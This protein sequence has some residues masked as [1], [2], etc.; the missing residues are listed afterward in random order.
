MDDNK[1]TFLKFSQ[2]S[3]GWEGHIALSESACTE[4]RDK[5]S[6]HSEW[7]IHP[8]FGEASRNLLKLLNPPFFPEDETLI[9]DPRI[10]ET[11]SVEFQ[12]I[13]RVTSDE[14][15]LEEGFCFG[16]DNRMIWGNRFTGVVAQL[17]YS[18]VDFI[19]AHNDTLTI[20][21]KKLKII[22][23]EIPPAIHE[24]DNNQ[25]ANIENISPLFLLSELFQLIAKQNSDRIVK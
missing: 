13:R 22:E 16:T 6:I 1:T 9:W 2:T 10:G 20:R 17:H 11:T 14:L 18:E 12:L 23:I 4:W 21:T 3:P 24:T 5:F 7:R 25:V 8:E 19:E 15:S